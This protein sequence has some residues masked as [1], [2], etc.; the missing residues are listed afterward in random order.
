MKKQAKAPSQS[1]IA[2]LKKELMT[3]ALRTY[4]RKLTAG[5]GGN[6]SV[7]LD[8][9]RF[10][11]SGSGSS[12]GFM[13]PADVLTVTMR[14]RVISGSKVPSSETPVHAAI[15]ERLRPAAILHSH[16]P[17]A[18]ALALA[19]IPFSPLTFEPYIVL[20]DVPVIPQ[21]SFNIIDVDPVVESLGSN[22][23]VIL[24]HHGVIAIGNTLQEAYLLTDLLEASAHAIAI[25]RSL[26]AIKPLP[27]VSSKTRRRLAKK[28]GLFS[29]SYNKLLC[30]AVNGNSDMTKMGRSFDFTTTV[31]FSI[32]ER[33]KRWCFSINQG[34]MRFDAAIK[35]PEFLF[36]G[37]SDMWERIFSG[38]V[39]FLVA[40]FQNRISMH[41]DTRRF[42]A[43][44]LPFQCLFENIPFPR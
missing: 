43:W 27:S 21:Q 3:I 29:Q 19:P 32:T 30:E 41:G 13:K 20:G 16:P 42:S 33:K 8:D 18:S 9:K 39:S 26:G 17:I 40:L 24:Q 4:E 35:S 36:A 14:G 10:L 28:T 11:I 22:K 1:T 5:T 38:R 2:L 23:V 15:Y 44:Y 7:R 12:L 6:I 31:G 34:R 37:P 25:G